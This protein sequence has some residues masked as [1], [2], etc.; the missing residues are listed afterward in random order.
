MQCYPLNHLFPVTFFLLFPSYPDGRKLCHLP[1]WFP[2]SNISL[3]IELIFVYNIQHKRCRYL[4]LTAF[5]SNFIDNLI[6]YTYKN[7]NII[8][9]YTRKLILA[10]SKLKW[11][12]TFL[13]SVSDIHTIFFNFSYKLIHENSRHRKNAL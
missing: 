5:T 9:K 4:N 13:A 7:F 8:L 6:Y 1:A 2:S 11:T 12:I 10:K 3:H